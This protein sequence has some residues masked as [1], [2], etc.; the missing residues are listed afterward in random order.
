MTLAILLAL[1]AAVSWG[2][3]S[4][5]AR[6][7]L[8]HMRSTTGTVISLVAGVVVVGALAWALYGAEMFALPAVTYAWFVLLGLI[9]YPLGRLLNFAGVRLAGVGRATPILAGAPLVAATLGVV[10]GGETVT[11]SLALGT[12]AIVAGVVLIVTERA[13]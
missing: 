3:S 2:A 11:L 4:V 8:Q 10:L 1:L 9:S 13:G 7:G 5:L 6:L 12:G